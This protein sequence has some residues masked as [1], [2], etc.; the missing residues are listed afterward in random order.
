MQS[1]LRKKT[2]EPGVAGR[3]FC[4]VISSLTHDLT[5]AR[6]QLVRLMHQV[7]PGGDRMY[8]GYN[9]A[10]TPGAG[11]NLRNR[12]RSS[13]PERLGGD[14]ENSHRTPQPQKPCRPTT[15]PGSK[16][17]GQPHLSVSFGNQRVEFIKQRDKR[18]QPRA[19]YSC[20]RPQKKVQNSC[21]EQQQC[22]RND[23]SDMSDMTDT[24]DRSGQSDSTC[25]NI[26]FDS[27]EP[28]PAPAP[29]P[30][31]Q[32]CCCNT[33]PG[34]KELLRSLKAGSCDLPRLQG[35]GSGD[36]AR[37]QGGGRRHDLGSQFAAQ[38]N[39]ITFQ[40]RERRLGPNL[41]KRF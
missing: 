12:N 31:C 4:E 27:P 39:D 32:R 14:K 10:N 25:V 37:L 13:A 9:G 2:Q 30:E 40:L 29:A 22:D 34:S 21:E 18:P 26:M 38:L 16:Q 3:E 17:S 36:L 35:G 23:M 15:V 20:E 5:K 6:N 7:K 1:Y 19:S 11:F 24:S 8:G 41:V 28:A 33:K